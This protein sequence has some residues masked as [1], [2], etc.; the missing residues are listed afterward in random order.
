[1]IDRTGLLFQPHFNHAVHTAVDAVE[2]SF[3]LDVQ[4]QFDDVEVAMLGRTGAQGGVG[5][6]RL[7]ADFHAV[8]HAAGV[9]AVDGS[10]IF[11]VEPLQ[12]LEQAFQ[13]L[14]S[15]FFLDGGA[16]LGT[17]VGQVVDAAA[18][19]VDI[20]HR[21]AAHHGKV[22]LLP[23]RRQQVQ[24]VALELCGAVAF[25]QVLEGDKMMLGR[26]QFLGGGG[27][28]ADG[29]AAIDLAG[30]GV[31][32]VTMQALCQLNGCRSLAHSGWAGNDNQRFGHSSFLSSLRYS[33]KSD[34]VR[35]TGAFLF[36]TSFFLVLCNGLG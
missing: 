29:D 23:Q 26:C 5:N 15:Q 19:G 22:A 36:C 24:H 17:D 34:D 21:A 25:L 4:G 1:M 28:G 2:Q 3:A 32:D 14:A 27:C 13:P 11:R 35:A 18:H 12:F 33:L 6:A 10:S 16:H 9:F 30:V 20:E 31:D 7:A 8:A